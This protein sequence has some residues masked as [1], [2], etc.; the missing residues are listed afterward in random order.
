MLPE[1]RLRLSPRRLHL[2]LRRSVLTCSICVWKRRKGSVVSIVHLLRQHPGR[3]L[4]M[5][6]ALLRANPLLLLAHLAVYLRAVSSMLLRLRRKCGRFSLRHRGRQ[7]AFL[8]E[9]EGHC[10]TLHQ[11]LKGQLFLDVKF[12]FLHNPLDFRRPR[13]LQRVHLLLDRLLT[14]T[15]GAIWRRK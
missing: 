7:P 6:L 5:L 3:M 8:G 1:R 13:V 2:L 14:T 9:R 4:R 15:L 12:L 10:L 11:N